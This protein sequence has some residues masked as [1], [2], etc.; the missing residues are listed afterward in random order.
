MAAAH[1]YILGCRFRASQVGGER[2]DDSVL[3]LTLLFSFYVHLLI[4][5]LSAPY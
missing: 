3:D 2:G 5:A 1:A 4:N